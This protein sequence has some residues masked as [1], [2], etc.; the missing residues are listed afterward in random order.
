MF[1]SPAISKFQKFL[2]DYYRLFQELTLGWETKDVSTINLGNGIG[3]KEFEELLRRKVVNIFKKLWGIQIDKITESRVIRSINIKKL[4]EGFLDDLDQGIDDWITSDWN[5]VYA[6]AV[7]VAATGKGQIAG[8]VDKIN[9]STGISTI[10]KPNTQRMI[11]FI[12]EQGLDLA[13]KLKVQQKKSLRNTLKRSLK[14]G[15][16]RDVTISDMKRNVSLTDRESQWLLNYEARQRK[17]LLKEFK[18]RFP[19]LKEEKIRARVENVV[20]RRKRRKYKFYQRSRSERFYRTE[21]VRARN[22][23]NIEA[24]YQA[25]E[26]GA[27]KNAKKKWVKRNQVDNWESSDKY[28]GKLIDF[29][30][31]FFVK[32]GRPRETT[33]LNGKGPGEINELCGLEFFAEKGDGKPIEVPFVPAKSIDE[34]EKFAEQLGVK[35]N[36]ENFEIDKANDINKVLNKYMRNPKL[37]GKLNFVS[38]QEGIYK[39]FLGKDNIIAFSAKERMENDLSLATYYKRQRS[40]GFFS[41]NDIINQKAVN[42]KLINSYKSGW[43]SYRNGFIGNVE[44]EFTHFIDQMLGLRKNKNI[45]KIW[46]SNYAGQIEKG[47]GRYANSEIGEFIAECYTEYNHSPNPRPLTKKIGKIIDKLLGV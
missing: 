47:V 6:E 31:D 12:D 25:T 45:L 43:L 42:K 38:D 32:F 21:L 34:A 46:Q 22:D 8:L 9:Q 3:Q 20:R 30:E 26:S 37:K 10:F 5:P 27:V 7:E 44:H 2:N 18:E 33:M 29:D 11:D 1:E 19:E 13:E 14:E 17:A 36:Y 28:N 4:P 40:I 16:T 41:F 15:W 39:H 23:G 35:V 24:I